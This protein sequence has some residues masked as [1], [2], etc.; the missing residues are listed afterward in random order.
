M[1]V[2][3]P[4]RRATADHVRRRRRRAA[5]RAG[6]RRRAGRGPPRRGSARPRPRAV[7]PRGRAAAPVRRAHRRRAGRAPP[8]AG[9][10]RCSTPWPARRCRRRGCGGRPR[11]SRTRSS[12]TPRARAR[13]STGWR[14][15]GVTTCSPHPATTSCAGL[16]CWTC[17]T[18]TRREVA[19]RL[20]VDRLVALVDVLVWVL[21]PQK[22]ADA[23]IHDRYLRPS[24]APRRGDGGGAQPGRPARAGCRSGR[25][26]PMSAGCLP[27]TASPMCRCW[28]TSAVRAV[29]L[30]RLRAVLIGA[31]AAHRAALRRVAADLDTVADDLDPTS[32]VGRLA[33]T[34]TSARSGR[35]S[36]RW[37]RRPAS[38]R[39]ARRSS[40][41]LCT[42]RWP[43]PAFRSPA[44]CG[45][46]AR[47]RCAG[48]TSTG[49]VRLR[50][51]A[52]PPCTTTTRPPT[53]RRP[54][55]APRCPRPVPSSGPAWTSPCAV[56][57]TTPPRA[58]PT[59]GRGSCA[60]PRARAPGDLADALDRAVATTDLGMTRRAALV[61]RGRR[62]AGAACRGGDR[63]GA[64]AGRALRADRAAAARSPSRRRSA[65][66]PLPTVLLIGGLLA[67][68][69]LALLA[70]MLA[71]LAARR[72]RARAEARLRDSV[73]D[74]AENAG[75]R[76]GAGRAGGV[77]RAA[78]CR[79]DAARIGHS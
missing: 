56:S 71:V 9:S 48:C 28:P 75:A 14:S 3:L 79:R 62:T 17:L 12:G 55:S 13:C 72:R 10:R 5:A 58:C 18:T 2:R 40:A 66:V 45:G 59:R 6:Q 36:R 20:E 60:T 54:R 63:R 78:G 22:Y 1:T 76:P 15:R 51:P 33:T 35:S 39:S 24:R 65:C 61:A 46:C 70:R 31:V 69:L 34:S 77:H 57:P 64:V 26:W 73:A 47:T 23:A 67:G 38:R 52:P 49:H 8:A 74:V 25:R 42:A 30:D 29:G 53:S 50:S 32:S 44:G 16:S 7:P 68:L 21:D 11:G 27:R 41:R 19:H 37:A 4:G 43:P